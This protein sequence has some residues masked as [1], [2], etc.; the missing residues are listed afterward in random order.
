MKLHKSITNREFKLLIKPKGL[1]RRRKITE[2]SD[3]ILKFCIK[4]K[5][6]FFHL[7]N[8]TTGL[9]NIYFYDTPGEDFRRN[10]VIL[11][12]RESRQ[13]DWVQDRSE[14]THKSRSHE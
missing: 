4:S 7:D 11:R 3:Q 12:V 8:A 6:D 14:E 9:R 5:V 1:D 2:L 10:N 13:N